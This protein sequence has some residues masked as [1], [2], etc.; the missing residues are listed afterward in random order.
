[1]LYKYEVNKCPDENKTLVKH[2]P[3][4][5]ISGQWNT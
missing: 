1:M 4:K 5:G 3:A 2:P